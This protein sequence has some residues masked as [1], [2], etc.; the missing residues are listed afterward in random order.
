MWRH[1]YICLLL[2]FGT[3]YTVAQVVINEVVSSN[4]NLVEDVFG[5][6]SDWIELYN[7]SASP[8]NLESYYLSDYEGYL[9][10]WGFP[11]VTIAANGYLLV[12]CSGNNI[13]DP[14]ELHTNFKL[15]QSGEKVF[16]S[17]ADG[18]VISSVEFGYIPTDQSYATYNYQTAKYLIC[19]EPTPG[20][21]NEISTGLFYSHTSGYYD[22]AFDLE[23][24]S[25]I[26]QSSVRCTRNGS[27]PSI[28][29]LEYTDPIEIVNVSN[30]SYN[31]SGIPTTPL[32]G[33]P[34]FVSWMWREPQSV[35]M[36]NVFRAGVFQA[37]SLTSK[38]VSLTYFVD[39]DMKT[40]YKYP[41]ASII[42][43]SLNLFGNENGIYVPGAI[44]GTIPFTYYPIG[45]FSQSG[46]EWEREIYLSF[47]ESDGELLFE[48]GAGMRIRGWGSSGFSQKSLN[49]YFREKYGLKKIE[50]P[51]FSY[52]DVADFKRLI[53]RNAGNDFPDGHFKD[54]YLTQVIKGLN[55][56]IQ[57]YEPIVV[58]INGEYWGMHNMREKMDR[59]HF[60]Y[61]YDLPEEDINVLGVCGSLEEGSNAGYSELIEYVETH[62]LATDEAYAYVSERLD[63]ASAIDYNI[64]EIYFANYDWPCNNYKMWNTNQPGSKWKYIIHDLDYTLGFN[65]L[66]TYDA[67]SMEHS[68][69]YTGPGWPNCGCSSV[70]F[71]NL[72]KNQDFVDQFVERFEYC[73]NNVFNPER[74]NQILDEFV[75]EYSIGMEEHI[76]RFGFPS[77]VSEWHNTIAFFREFIDKRPCVMREN[78][79]AFFDLE[80]FNYNCSQLVE[81]PEHVVK[82]RETINAPLFDKAPW[83]LYPNPNNG[84]FY[85]HNNSG[86]DFER[87][88]L[89]IYDLM[90][91][92][93]FV[94]E[95]FQIKSKNRTY[96]HIDELQGGIYIVE[97]QSGN[98]KETFKLF[99]QE[100]V[101]E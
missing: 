46:S 88:D 68:V 30:G 44:Y 73:M 58:F 27:N 62:D 89:K 13:L 60:K 49:I 74:M 18:T 33:A 22:E 8:V 23:L 34:N 6:T 59:H 76:E 56:E 86:I 85:I 9:P 14:N 25:P 11:D 52:S 26:A 71:R 24:Y 51:L 4:E 15:S 90:G 100:E 57:E 38:V 48:S 81:V 7:T 77:S 42:T 75:A 63:I 79:K 45:N 99:I 16:L 84:W 65:D 36:S 53:F 67:Q 64:S 17:D 92:T 96:L 39:P 3:Q 35:Y 70:I 37:D 12:F 43:D 97:V 5:K 47:F 28:D 91:K 32:E 95:S 61:K 80:S 2:I 10:M 93:V 66:C 1:L 69:N 50:S 29:D 31:F 82:E 87:G 55:I 78:I 72:L 94:K 54:S 41:V 20:E 21:N 40:R 101:G 83:Q 19:S 98:R